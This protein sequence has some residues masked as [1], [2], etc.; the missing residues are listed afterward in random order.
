MSATIFP[1]T[2]VLLAGG[3]GTPIFNR[4]D[5]IELARRLKSEG[6]RVLRIDHPIDPIKEDELETL[7]GS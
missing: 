4:E 7:L 6:H 2:I 3:V 5:A 1:Y